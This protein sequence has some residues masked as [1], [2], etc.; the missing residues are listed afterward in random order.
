[1]IILALLDL[2]V[3]VTLV[4]LAVWLLRTPDLYRA[5]VLLVSFGLIAAVAWSRLNAPDVALA[6]AAIGAGLTGALFWNALG[7]LSPLGERPAGKSH[8]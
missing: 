3:A 6:E 8:E 4:L 2:L 5:T 7:R 1:M